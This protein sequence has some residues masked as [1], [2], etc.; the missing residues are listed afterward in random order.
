M[1]SLRFPHRE[2][3]EFIVEFISRLILIALAYSLKQL[4]K[5]ALWVL[6]GFGKFLLRQLEGLATDLRKAL[7]GRLVGWAVTL[8]ALFFV[9]TWWHYDWALRPTL[10]FFKSLLS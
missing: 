4:G 9:A 1:T 3:N 5:A 7:V 6:Q 8:F 2:Q 10:E